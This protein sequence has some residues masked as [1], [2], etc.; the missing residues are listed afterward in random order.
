MSQAPE[1]PASA[2]FVIPEDAHV[3]LIQLHQHLRL[4]AWLADIGGPASREDAHLRPDALAWW[5]TRVCRDIERIVEA[6][7]WSRLDTTQ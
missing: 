1:A 7:Y 4:Q 6:T 2:G 5:F 3:E